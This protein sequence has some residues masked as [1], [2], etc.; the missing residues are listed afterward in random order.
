MV[1]SP[2]PEATIL[3]SGEKWVEAMPPEWLPTSLGADGL[4]VSAW[5]A[6]AARTRPKAAR[7]RGDMCRASCVRAGWEVEGI[8]GVR[9]REDVA[10]QFRARRCRRE[11]PHADA[12]VK[13]GMFIAGR[14][15]AR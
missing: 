10:G 15:Q 11:Y 9:A 4:R 5:A 3:P 2:P 1:L 8:D 7:M 6:M 12:G 13:A 14:P